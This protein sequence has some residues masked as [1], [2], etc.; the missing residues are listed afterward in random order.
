MIACQR[1][2]VAQYQKKIKFI[3]N[4]TLTEKLKRFS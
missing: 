3:G 4:G 1:A 2:M